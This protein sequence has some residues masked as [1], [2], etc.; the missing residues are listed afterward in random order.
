MM[1]SSH[2]FIRCVQNRF[3]LLREHDIISKRGLSI[4]YIVIALG[5]NLILKVC[6]YLT[7]RKPDGHLKWVI[8]LL[9]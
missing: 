3:N 9:M 5:I 8:T 2:V 1:S 7:I 4:V 6:N